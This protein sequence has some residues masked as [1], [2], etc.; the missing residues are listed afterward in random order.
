M[1][2]TKIIF[3]RAVETPL[4]FAQVKT[5]NIYRGEAEIIQLL[6]LK[7]EKYLQNC[8]IKNGFGRIVA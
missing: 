6:V 5:K 8:I 3:A 4:S 1:Y 7:Y 2:L